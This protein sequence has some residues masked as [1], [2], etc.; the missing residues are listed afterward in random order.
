MAG[1]VVGLFLL[2]ETASRPV[3]VACGFGAVLAL[4]ALDR[5]ALRTNGDW[6]SSWIDCDT[7]DVARLMVTARGVVGCLFGNEAQ[8]FW[9][10]TVLS[11]GLKSPSRMILI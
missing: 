5:L 10:V 8:L 3:V 7:A 6:F 1:L 4:G 2:W 11:K 9:L